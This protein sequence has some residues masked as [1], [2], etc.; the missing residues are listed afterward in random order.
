MVD[1]S[2]LVITLGFDMVEYHPRLWNPRGDKTIVHAD[3]LPAEIDEHYHASVEL[4]G[5]L[6]HTLWMLNERLDASPLEN[7][8]L[9]GQA[10]LRARFGEELAAHADDDTAD[11]IRP[12]KAL[13]D[14][15]QV[16]GPHDVL[17]SR[18]R[19]PQNVDRAPLPL[20]RA[21]HLPDP[22]RLLL[23]GLCAAR[24]DC[25]E[26]V[27]PDRQVLAICGDA[28]FL[29]NV[30]EMETATR[31]GVNLAVMVWED[32]E[33]GLIAWKQEAEFGHHTDL[34]FGN[35]D[36]MALAG[37]FGWHGHR[38]ERSAELAGALTTA[39][40]EPGPSLV[41]IPIDYRENMLL[42]RRL[43]EI[44]QPGIVS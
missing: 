15:R 24:C 4:V 28:G 36:W 14:A 21:E 33:Y 27:H 44:T 11:A 20:P 31:L 40:A 37:A 10:D 9:G 17:L 26:L 35:P 3:F 16:L 19:R 7:L 30:Q 8:D 43:G 25:G 29:M 5:D 39:L 32:Q 22:E 2:D 23:D 34:S 18:R 38:V 13:W 6:A 1:E 41:V 42:T 12:Q